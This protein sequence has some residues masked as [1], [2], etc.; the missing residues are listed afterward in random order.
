MLRRCIMT[1]SELNCILEKILPPYKEAMEKAA[2]RQASLAKPPRSLGKLEDISIKLAGITGKVENRIDK[3]RVLVFASDNG[4]V[5]EGVAVTPKSVTLSQSVNMTRHITGMSALASYFNDSVCVTDVGIDSDIKINGIVDRKIRRGTSNIRLGPAM[6]RE[7]AILAIGHGI[8]AV[9]NAV[10]D[11]VSAVGV[12]EMGIGNT[13]TSA[14]V[15]AAL[16][17]RDPYEVTG[18]GSGLTDEAY[19]LK[20]RVVADAI[21]VNRPDPDDPIDTVSKV[22]GFDIAAMA[23]AYIGCALYRVPAAVDGFI[24][25]VAALAA[26]R[27]CPLVK[28]HIFLSHASS[29]PGYRIAAEELGLSPF[30]L[31]DMRLGEGSGCPLAFRVLQ[32]ACAAMCGMATFDEAA[33]DDGYLD[34]I[35][36]IGAF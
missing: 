1:G 6:T 13:T 20:K 18:R 3:C 16:T 25:I 31:L 7:E 19:E 4:V 26:V 5:S 32:A 8:E 12:G 9:E 24:S 22:G 21:A 14:A 35:K 17:G 11:G 10:E 33:I 28:D 36:N 15:L 23:G 2:E 29:E 30:L 34:S 27:I